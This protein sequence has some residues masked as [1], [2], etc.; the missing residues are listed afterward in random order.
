MAKKL[1]HSDI[2]IGTKV[3]ILIGSHT[4]EIGTYNGMKN[5]CNW[6]VITFAN[7]DELM[8]SDEFEV[9]KEK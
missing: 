1:F 7:G 3:K 6:H 4:G 9:I 2:P 8:N 5:N